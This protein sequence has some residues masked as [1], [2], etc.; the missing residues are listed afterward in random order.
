ME[1][2]FYC[3]S[4]NDI[5]VSIQTGMKQ[6]PSDAE[7]ASFKAIIKAAIPFTHSTSNM[8]IRPN[9]TGEKYGQYQI[10]LNVTPTNA[11]PRM[12]VKLL[13]QSF[14]DENKHEE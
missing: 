1:G 11:C 6:K 4:G 7:I 8:Q 9:S 14:V 12:A 10:R 13:K 5:I 2:L 3:L